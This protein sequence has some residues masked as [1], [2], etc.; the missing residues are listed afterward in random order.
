MFVE[1]MTRR[2]IGVGDG[3]D[4]DPDRGTAAAN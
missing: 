4:E 3:I 2:L 1:T